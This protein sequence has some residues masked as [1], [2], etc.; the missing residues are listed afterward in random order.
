MASYMYTSATGSNWDDDDDDFAPTVYAGAVAEFGAADLAKIALANARLA[1]QDL[2]NQPATEDEQAQERT[3]SSATTATPPQADYHI[4][5][6]YYP[7]YA[8][9]MTE[10]WETDHCRRPAYTALSS[11]GGCI[12]PYER[13]NYSTNWKATKL[14]MGASMKNATMMAPS[15]LR[16]TK[17]WVSDSLEEYVEDRGY[18]WLSLPVPQIPTPRLSHEESSDEERDETHTPPNTP[19]MAQVNKCEV[20]SEEYNPNIGAIDLTI[21]STKT[22]NTEIAHEFTNFSSIAEYLDVDQVL[23]VAGRHLLNA[24]INEAAVQAIVSGMKARSTVELT[25]SHADAIQAISSPARDATEIATAAYKQLSDG[26]NDVTIAPADSQTAL[27]DSTSILSTPTAAPRR[28]S[29]DLK[30]I[31]DPTNTLL[32]WNT[33]AAGWF[34]LSS[35]PWGCMAVATAG[36]LVDV[37]VFIARH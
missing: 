10:L 34:V 6:E 26:K 19:S 14:Q 36:V 35:M 18:E 1:L 9:Y 13:R 5:T 20:H 37:A 25:S 3:P 2:K 29:P 33:V 17:T 30:C 31:V 11:N 21:Q 7:C 15:T 12:Y 24:D 27:G 23:G 16:L 8:Q 28:P 4:D 22:T 32:V